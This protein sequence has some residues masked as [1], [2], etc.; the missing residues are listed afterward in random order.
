MPT[1]TNVRRVN[2]KAKRTEYIVACMDGVEPII[3]PAYDCRESYTQCGA[4][5]NPRMGMFTWIHTILAGAK[6]RRNVAYYTGYVD[7]Y[8]AKTL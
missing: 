3:S 7:Q 6:V 2:M 8:K 1:S 5:R 4:V